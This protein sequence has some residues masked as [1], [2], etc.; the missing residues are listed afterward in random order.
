MMTEILHD[1]E[2]MV[3][4]PELNIA[5]KMS[6]NEYEANTPYVE[7]IIEQWGPA[8]GHL[9]SDGQNLII[10]GKQYGNLFVGVQP[11]FG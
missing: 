7:D 2:A 1:P 4:S 3:G 6:V 9:N 10:Y 11:T 5:Y 8:P